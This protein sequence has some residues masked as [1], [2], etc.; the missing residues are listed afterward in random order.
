[1]QLS[2]V[3]NN[4]RATMRRF[5][6]GLA[7]AATMAGPL[8]VVGQARAQDLPTFRLTLKDHK[9]DPPALTVPAGQRFVLIVRNA[10]DTP[11]EFESK[12][13]GAEKVVSA[14]REA[15]I[16]LGPLKSGAYPFADE[17]HEDSAKG[18]LTVAGE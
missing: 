14:G 13:L 10:D 6:M 2:F 18:V 12:R 15:T 1:M 16:R 17:Y 5:V 9:F 8:A 3:C 4:W 11:A 7:L